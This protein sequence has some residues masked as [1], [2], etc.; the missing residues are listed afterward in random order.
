MRRREYACGCKYKA[1]MYT[2]LNRDDWIKWKYE[3][4]FAG[5]CEVCYDCWRKQ[6]SI[7]I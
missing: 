1:T 7:S 3:K 4:G 6:K 5:T 2:I